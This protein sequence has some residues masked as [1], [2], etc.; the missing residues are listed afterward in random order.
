MHFPGVR[1]K[2]S[3]VTFAHYELV[4][5]KPT[6]MQRVCTGCGNNPQASEW[7]QCAGCGKT[8]YEMPRKWKPAPN[9]PICDYCCKEM[10]DVEKCYDPFYADVKNEIIE[11]NI[12]SDCYTMR[13]REV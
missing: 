1:H 5:G 12:C 4:D 11:V 9:M 10:P 2:R 8:G 3:S 7:D 6:L 13:A